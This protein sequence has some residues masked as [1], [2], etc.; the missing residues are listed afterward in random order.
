VRARV[1]LLGVS[2]PDAVPIARRMAPILQP[3]WR[4]EAARLTREF[5]SAGTVHL[6]LDR[7]QIDDSRVLVAYVLV[8]D[9]VLNEQ[10]LKAGLARLDLRPGDSSS[11]VRRLRKA[12][13][14]AK[15]HRRGIWADPARLAASSR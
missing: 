8:G 6:R 11:M 13:S 3:N 1:R 2:A 14:E 12:E 10:L 7:R 5:V 15:T 9:R 4:H